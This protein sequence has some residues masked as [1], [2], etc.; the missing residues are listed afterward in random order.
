MSLYGAIN[1]ASRA[2]SRKNRAQVRVPK[3]ELNARMATVQS[4]N[5][6]AH[7]ATVIF[8]NSANSFVASYSSHYAPHVGDTC[9][10]LFIGTSPLI[11]ANAQ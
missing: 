11:L 7:T 2:L 5:S 10:I 8:A 9:W 6:I 3:A 4:V 1:R